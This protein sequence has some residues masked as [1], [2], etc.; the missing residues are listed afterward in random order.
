[1][2]NEAT[3]ASLVRMVKWCEMHAPKKFGHLSYPATKTTK[4]RRWVFEILW[5]FIL[6]TVP[7]S[8]V[9]ECSHSS[10]APKPPQPSKPMRFR[11]LR[12]ILVRFS[13]RPGEDT[14]LVDLVE[15]REIEVIPCDSIGVIWDPS[16]VVWNREENES[17]GWRLQHQPSRSLELP[18]QLAQVFVYPLGQLQWYLSRGPAGDWR[19]PG[20]RPNTWPWLPRGGTQGSIQ[21]SPE[22]PKKM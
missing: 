3:S 10:T 1:M 11:S 17:M 2:G 7:P 19:I 9:L 16:V 20:P 18:E 22:S 14:D 4:T 15:N 8:P 21:W 6:L 5:V 13:A 12:L